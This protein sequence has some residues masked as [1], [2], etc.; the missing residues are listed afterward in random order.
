MKGA[1]AGTALEDW[2]RL[3]VILI[4]VIFTAV[5]LIVFLKT[6]MGLAIRAT[7]DNPEMVRASS[8]DPV[9][10]TVVGLCVANAFTGLSGCLMAQYQKS[11][12][13]NIGSGMVTIAL[14]SLLIGRA[15]FGKGQIRLRVLG[16]VIGAFLFR[17]VYTLAL[18]LRMP[19]YMLKLVSSVI[20][21]IAIAGPYFKSRLPLMKRKLAIRKAERAEKKGGRDA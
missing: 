17:L 14:A 7:G 10:P 11:V 2:S 3:I 8:I 5:F 1:L 16:A 9:L 13:I 21:I 4:F 20:G 6:R 12:D 18:R 15:F 19:A